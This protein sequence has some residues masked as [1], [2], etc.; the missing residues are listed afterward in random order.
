[1]TERGHERGDTDTALELLRLAGPRTEASPD[2]EARV[3]AA[4]RAHWLGSV[5]ARRRRRWQWRAAA[6]AAAAAAVVAVVVPRFTATVGT[7]ELAAIEVL[8]GDVRTGAAHPLLPA[9][10]G[11]GLRRGS[12]LETGADGRAALRLADGASLR[13]DTG[14]R[15]TLEGPDRIS[16]ESGAVYIDSGTEPA[17]RQPVRIETARGSVQE[18]GTQFEVR[19]L[20]ESLRVRVREGRVRMSWHETDDELV[21]GQQALLNDRG[22]LELGPVAPTDPGWSWLLEVAPAFPLE[23]ASAAAYL[24]WV[25]RETGLELRWAEPRLAAAAEGMLLHGDA[26][27]LRPDETLGVVLPT[28]GLGHEV[29]QGT[30]IVHSSSR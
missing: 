20:P 25:E 4:V 18:V 9:A 30:L 19:L 17:D 1:M 11:A 10:L 16:L 2:R 13:I 27:G 7:A 8:L 5:A 24:R 21:A 23:G 26:A 3:T 15:I 14:S 12:V 6:L 29:N 28:C 22:E